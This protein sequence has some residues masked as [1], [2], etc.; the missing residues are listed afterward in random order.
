MKI[1]EDRQFLIMQ[2]NV[3]SSCSLEGVDAL[4]SAE[5]ERKVAREIQQQ[6]YAAKV[7]AGAS[8]SAT[9]EQEHN[10]HI[11]SSSSSSISS[12]EEFQV[13]SPEMKHQPKQ[14]R[15]NFLDDPNVTGALDRV[16]LPDRGATY[17]VGAVAK[18]LGHDVSTVTLS[19]SSIRRSS[20]R[21]RQEATLHK[22]FMQYSQK[23]HKI[24]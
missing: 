14:P 11:Q 7:A 12:D 13:S 23:L 10:V 1:E 5:E 22:E 17:V 8:S 21:N 18:A 20:C 16:N 9:A 15:V 4:L 19:R 6:N 3:V 24:T 2:R